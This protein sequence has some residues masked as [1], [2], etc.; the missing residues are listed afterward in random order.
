MQT[1]IVGIEFCEILYETFFQLLWC[2][3]TQNKRLHIWRS[4]NVTFDT[5]DSGIC[6]FNKRST[7]KSYFRSLQSFVTST[8]LQWRF[9]NLRPSQTE[10]PLFACCKWLLKV[11]SANITYINFRIPNIKSGVD[12]RPF[13][14]RVLQKQIFRPI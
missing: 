4:V 3:Q 11:T 1:W 8:I 13:N 9:V 14:I 12:A 2:C 5:W 10:W 6:G 7:A